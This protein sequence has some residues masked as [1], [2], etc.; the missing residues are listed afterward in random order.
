M[1]NSQ[2]HVLKN[3]PKTTYIILGNNSTMIYP[4]IESVHNNC[5]VV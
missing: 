1:K 2:S 3:F 4:T 5:E